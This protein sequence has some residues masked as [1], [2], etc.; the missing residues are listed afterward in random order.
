MLIKGTDAWEMVCCL[1][2]NQVIKL[3]TDGESVQTTM[4]GEQLQHV[5]EAPFEAAK[6][7]GAQG[8]LNHAEVS[9]NAVLAPNPQTLDLHLFLAL[10]DPEPYLGTEAGQ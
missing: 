3:L 2:V 9:G 5:Q 4:P 8:I 7:V 1:D 6:Q 10:H